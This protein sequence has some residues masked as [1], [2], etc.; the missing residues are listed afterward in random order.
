MPVRPNF[1]TSIKNSDAALPACVKTPNGPLRIGVTQ[2]PTQSDAARDAA[3]VTEAHAMIISAQACPS[4]IR[5]GRTHDGAL[6]R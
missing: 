6:L 2:H 1:D 4:L 3:S 5:Y